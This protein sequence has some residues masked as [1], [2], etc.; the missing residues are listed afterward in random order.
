MKKELWEKS[1]NPKVRIQKYNYQYFLNLL[2]F[3][4]IRVIKYYHD[5]DSNFAKSLK[6]MLLICSPLFSHVLFIA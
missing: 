6:I 3:S 4:E 2:T 5:K 1:T